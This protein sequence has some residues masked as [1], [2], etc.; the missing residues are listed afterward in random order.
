MGERH[1]VLSALI[2]NFLTERYI[3]LF[4][5]ARIRGPLFEKDVGDVIILPLLRLAGLRKLLKTPHSWTCGAW[6]LVPKGTSRSANHLSTPEHTGIGRP[7]MTGAI[8]R[9]YKSEPQPQFTQSEL[10]RRMITSMLFSFD[11]INSPKAY[12]IPRVRNPV[13]RV[14]GSK[15]AFLGGVSIEHGWWSLCCLPDPGCSHV[16]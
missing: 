9:G 11:T 6:V 4:V 2:R 3:C 10:W 14:A 7:R 8:G 13:S 16:R 1:I 12:R 15:N 5:G